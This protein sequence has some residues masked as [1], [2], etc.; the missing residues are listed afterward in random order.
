MKAIKTGNIYQ[1]YDDEMKTF[2]QLP[3]QTYCVRFSKMTGFFLEKRSNLKVKETKVYGVHSIKVNKVFKTF[4]SFIRNL[5][6][7]LSG[8]KGM[9]KSMFANMLAEGALEK[10]IPVI[11]VDSFIPGIASF[12]ESIDQEVLVLFDE[13][14]KTFGGVKVGD[15]EASPQDSMLG[16]FDGMSAGKKLFVVTCN[17]LRNM[18]DYLINRPGRFHYHF[19]FD[20]PTP[21]EIKEYLHDKLEEQYWE[22]IEKVISFSFKVNLNYDCLRAIVYELNTGEKFEDAIKDLNIVNLNSKYYNATLYFEDGTVMS[23]SS[24]G[25]NLFSK[26]SDEMFW[27]G[28]KDSDYTIS[29]EFN[30]SSCKHDVEKGATI[31]MGE[32]LILDYDKEYCTEEE[33]NEMKKLKPKYL[34]ITS[35]KGRNIHYTV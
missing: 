11:I 14:D 27:I 2:D 7:I 5:G 15:N 34:A 24:V 32:D 33:V 28:K 23:N 26:N 31:V 13:F 35:K 3:A 18:S 9:G 22:E 17:D 1:I 4:E 10:G 21:E 20:Y 30:T 25:I 8:D 29:V 6:V 19:R 12:I 16:L